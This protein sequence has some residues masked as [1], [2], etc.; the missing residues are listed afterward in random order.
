MR[1]D[2]VEDTLHAFLWEQDGDWCWEILDD[3]GQLLREGSRAE[4]Y[5]AGADVLSKLRELRHEIP[6]VAYAQA[7]AR[8]LTRPQLLREGW[9]YHI[10]EAERLHAIELPASGGGALY[11]VGQIMT[12]AREQTLRLM[13]WHASMALAYATRLNEQP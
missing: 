8:L 6:L 10:G 4:R 11:P 1:F 12:T 5:D 9:A 3:D 7:T 2:D 13:D